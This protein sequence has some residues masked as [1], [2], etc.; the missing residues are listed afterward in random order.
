M[1]KQLLI[2]CLIL[3]GVNVL[4]SQKPTL[5]IVDSLYRFSSIKVPLGK[6][7]SM[8]ST[9]QKQQNGHSRGF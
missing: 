5:R 8:P 6:V 1:K 9:Y 4:L 2:F 7:I 3:G